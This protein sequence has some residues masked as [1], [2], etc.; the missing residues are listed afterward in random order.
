MFLVL[1]HVL[2]METIKIGDLLFRKDYFNMPAYIYVCIVYCCAI[3]EVM[4][5]VI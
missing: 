1:E 5:R 2:K 3:V 4:Q